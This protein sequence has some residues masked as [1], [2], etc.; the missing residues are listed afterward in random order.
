LERDVVDHP[1][2]STF[3]GGRS[4]SPGTGSVAPQISLP[5]GGGAIRGIGEK[6]STATLTGTG[7]LSIPIA[8]SPGRSGFAPQL[9][10]AY[11]S[12]AG[13]GPFGFG[14]SLA[15]PAIT[16]RTDK[17]LPKYRDAEESDVFL[18][19]GAEDLVPVLVQDGGGEWGG[20]KV[21]PR[22][23]YAITPY[24]PRIEGLF[25][26]I[27]RWTRLSDG[28]TY[29]R[30][31]SKDNVTS[32][33][34]RTAESRIADP[35]D[36]GRVFSWLISQSQDDRG[37][38]IVYSYAEE[39]STQIDL[40]RVNERNRMAPGRRSA[41]R[42]LTRIK[43]GNTPSQLTEPDVTRLSWLFEVAF[44]YGEGYFEEA[45]PDAE[46]RVFAS[47]TL[48]PAGAW[49]A[50]QDPFSQYRS[51]FEVRTYRLCR[52]ILMFHH[53]ADEL[54]APD[55]LVRST[56]FEYKESAVAS[57]IASLTESG[58]TRQPDGTYLKKSLP[59]LEFDYTEVRLDETVREIDASSL[60][61][62]P[63]GA[64][65]TRYQWV[66][67]DSD[68]LTGIL[69]EQ[70]NAWYYKRNLGGGTFGSIERV[71]PRPSIAALNAGR[72]Q[73]LDLAGAGHLDL[74]QFDGPMA[75]Y[76]ARRSDGGWERFRPFKSP[77]NIDTT[78]PNLRFVDVTGDGFP[79]VLISED[80]DFTW[81]ESLSKDGFAPAAHSPKGWDEEQGPAL[82]F[83]DPTQS[84][85]L[86]DMAGDGLSDIV[87]IRY[88]EVCYWP[89]LGYG[90]FGPKVTM[91]NA[92][93]FESYDRFEP[94]RIRLADIDGSGNADIIYVGHEGVTLYFNQSG[95]SWSAPR[96]LA[97]FPRVDDLTSVA[98]TDLNGN[99]TACLV[100]SSP[101]A[102]D[103]GRPMRYIDLMG[104]QKPH[105]LIYSTNNMSSETRVR[106]AAS[107][108]F[109]LQDRL[110]GRPW[111]TRLPFP[112]HVVERVETRDLV[113]NTRLVS[114]YRY[115]HGYYDGVEREFR[116]FAYVE[117][118]DD[119]QLVGELT[120]PPVLTRTWFHDGAFAEE[121]KL[122]A[123]FKDPANREFFLGDSQAGLLPDIDL[124]PNLTA[125]ETREAA[126]AL[127]GNI[128]RQETYAEDGSDKSS[129][130]YSICEYNF[131]LI[132]LQ[133]RGPNRHAVFFN[134]PNETV[135]YHYERNL[136]D[137]RISHALTLAVDDYGNVL[138]SVAIGYRRRIPAFAEQG[139]TLATLDECRYTN[140]ILQDDAYRVPL[141][142]EVSTYELTAPSLQ[143][144]VPLAF[145]AVEAIAAVAGEITYE[146]QP[147]PLQANKRLIE[148]VR[149]IYRK[150][151]LSDFLPVGQADSLALPGETYKLA[152][153][154]GLLENFRSR[155]TPAALTA[156]LSG[157]D[158]GYRDVEG[159]GRLWSPSGRV[160]YSPNP[161]DTAAQ[162]LA[163]A[164]A[165]FF[166]PHRFQDPFG[167]VATVAYDAKYTLTLVSIV[168]AVGNE[169][170]A[171]TDYRVLQPSSVT[172]PNGNRAE[173]RYD[174][175]GM[176]AGTAL[177][178]KAAGAVEGDSFDD[179][180]ADLSPA[181]TGAFFDSD[182]P[183]TL[184][185]GLLGTAST[186]IVYD[187]DRVPACATSIAR[188][189]HVSALAVGQ[190]T[191]VQLVFAYSDGFGREAQVKLQA[192][193]GPLEPNDPA[194]PVRA[195]RWVSTGAIVYNNKGKPVRQFEPFFS[196]SP[197]FGIETWGVSST[198]FY[199]PAGR[200]VAT[201]HPSHTFEKIVFDP[202]RQTAY[203]VNDTVSF[204]PKT[205]PDVGEYFRRLPDA[206][207]LPT[208]YQRRH[209]G[210]LGPDEQAAAEKAAQHADTPTVSHS[211]VL[212]R[213]FRTVVD[214]GKDPGG[215]DQQYPTRTVLDIEGNPRE[216]IDALDRVVMRYDYD[217]LG[218]RLHQA[219]MEA[220][221]RW[222]LTDV[223]GKPI[224]AWNGRNYA[225]RTEYDALRR[226]LNS[227]VQ[228]GDA[229]G[230]DA[231]GLAQEILF[232]RTVYGD[233]PETGLTDTQQ[234]QANL[235][236][237][238]FRFGDGA[239]IV[240]TDR[241]DFKGNS[242]VGT[243]RFTLDYKNA[244]DW[245]RSPQLENEPFTTTTEFDALN[246][247]I[248]VT[249]PDGSVFRPSFNAANLL[250][251]V[252]VNLRGARQDGQPV[253]TSFVTNIDYDARGRRTLIEYGNGAATAYSYDDTTFRLIRLRTTRAPGQG[254]LESQ[255][256]KDPSIVQDLRYTHDPVGNIT[257]VDDQ[258]LQAVF[259]ANQRV[260]P[261]A[262]YTYDPLYR[263]IAA[264]GREHI[265][266]SGFAFA[267]ANGNYRDYPF[268]GAAQQNDLQALRNYVELYDYDPVGNFRSLVH[269]ATNGGWTRTYAYE[270]SSLVEPAR[271]SNRLSLTALQTSPVPPAEPYS[272]DP[273]GNTTRMPHLPMMRWNFK[274][275]LSA[276]SRQVVNTDVP[277]TTYYVQ[278]AGNRRARK[279]T[280][281]QDGTP[282]SM[283][284]YLGSLEIYREFD[285]AGD[286]VTLQ[287]ET[288]HVMDD[289]QRVALVETRTQGDDGSP[290]Q[291]VRYQL[292]NHL[293]SS[294]W[295][296]D[297]DG[298]ILSYEEYYP[299]GGT[300]YQAVNTGVGIS[301]GRYRF[302]GMERD[303]ESG[304]CYH[305]G[306][307]YTP[308][309]GRWLSCDPIGIK[310]SINLYE[311]SNNN[312]CVWVDE[313]GQAPKKKSS[314][315]KA[316]GAQNMGTLMHSY[317]LAGLAVRAQKL[318]LHAAIEV[319]TKHG[320]S[321][322][323]KDV[324]SVDLV[325]ESAGVY[326]LYDLK[327]KGTSRDWVNKYVEFYPN[328][329]AVRGT[330]LEEEKY[331]E[332]LAP[333]FYYDAQ[334]P[335]QIFAI[336][337]SLP[338][339]SGVIDY[340]YE[341][342]KIE[343]FTRERQREIVEEAGFKYQESKLRLLEPV[344]DSDAWI[345]GNLPSPEWQVI[346]VGLADHILRKQEMDREDKERE[347]KATEVRAW[348]K[349]AKDM[350]RMKAAMDGVIISGQ[351]QLSNA[352]FEYNTMIAPAL[353]GAGAPEEVPIEVP[354]APASWW[355]LPVLEPSH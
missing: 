326:H 152:L 53:F 81:H 215:N 207:Y 116:G 180:V 52:R 201:L 281:R 111:I 148:R 311:Y 304:L 95:N 286:T 220:G 59:K 121:R 104:G 110:E 182:D 86:A 294:A 261:T 258:A 257:R 335:D 171:E 157:A 21:P 264:T 169:T 199:D 292:A 300:A 267:P 20:E 130:P 342:I 332:I 299:Y 168:D 63:C 35:D 219:S 284:F 120:L 132:C 251:T 150:N 27:E 226:P 260:D 153:T 222:M 343:D 262:D 65:G 139:T 177:R 206:D 319:S 4:S 144:A 25:S 108:K 329:G 151:D 178:G 331:R 126:R 280:E 55:Y 330:I 275:E 40:S 302:T 80:A 181:Q 115:R 185:A 191:R 355:R 79:D 44:D 196:A 289:A 203:D 64:S 57:F 298:R 170:T 49:P 97:S 137:P 229:S 61:N 68:G 158:G 14:W 173:A 345:Q 9:T 69:T 165:H 75:G 248:A 163:S 250:E 239:G 123:Y 305:G 313:D 287:R 339:K 188:E 349:M 184:A 41:N 296:L 197:R 134:H 279:I 22:D 36:P 154:P 277:E 124:P 337:L 10:L 276:T 161:A 212:G 92:P 107:T 46:G 179:F 93:L 245:S 190:Q 67:L 141:P 96:R 242:L 50:R 94:R 324:G 43:Y 155:A 143:G 273:H 282:K 28:D 142:A 101:L 78:D 38:V 307:Y 325:L 77:A 100:W 295:E 98:A 18:L 268:V 66:D 318:G 174:A 60:E 238:P 352:Q 186:R 7:S 15:Q 129:L 193:P 83:A 23:G 39:D 223:A 225:F 114:T 74:V 16:R 195:P 102:A 254:E 317:V 127:K 278:G 314:P 224:R 13:N 312:P 128:L 216:V 105:L 209:A 164:R 291:L 308:W 6:F 140:A 205:D 301:P 293:G 338:D 263:L 221:E 320:G 37:N 227:Y 321:R 183:N 73:F 62:L 109:Y 19:S 189:T 117:Q 47:A 243:R 51:G 32:F 247:A 5:R 176:V 232:E 125:D 118:R 34:G 231:Q 218:T 297:R 310:E 8:A 160:F 256:L 204:E 88:G 249:S 156:I 233:S 234:K 237:K 252:D 3:D 200:A 213:L 149:T 350:E 202:W 42:Y 48:T 33:Y 290:G 90:R 147:D 208:W 133:P 347:R 348:V 271:H 344:A 1:P 269:Q 230:P 76:Q 309:L 353:G 253:W 136:D 91:D 167:N 283:R 334:F 119:E 159:D 244:P 82:V 26:R 54:G 270:E 72:Q 266:Q 274:D 288:L 56:E 228:G 323:G 211:D 306:R 322:N 241:Y 187:L 333:V 84:I 11:D 175:L 336:T 354:A 17:G 328:A 303:E 145:A 192:E 113:S 265:G 240:T 272:Y 259:H 214:K 351:M 138:K 71:A 341:R 103:G 24:R 285:P 30:S 146:A 172:D 87:R 135:D 162:E 346:H 255:I 112:V 122:E 29:W 85:F 236:G 99:G 31:I 316:G 198:L 12:A 315:G 70:A 166:A 235:R 194:S 340:E 246:R 89:N 217:M 210:E 45:L 327:K 2:D 58:Y 106:Y 131:R